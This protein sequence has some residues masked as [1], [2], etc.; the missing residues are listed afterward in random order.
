M[1]TTT[2][3]VTLDEKTRKRL[4]KLGETKQRSLHWLMKEAIARYLETEERYELESGEDFA[5]WQRHVDTGAALSHEEAK[6]RL[7]ALAKDAAH[8]VKSS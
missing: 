8:K 2:I 5:R 6:A 7:E 4:K 1:A 3:G